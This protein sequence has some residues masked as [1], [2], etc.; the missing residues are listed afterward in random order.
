MAKKRLTI[1]LDESIYKKLTEQAKEAGLTKS[2]YLTTLI[3]NQSKQK[4]QQ[5]RKAQAGTWTFLRKFNYL[6][7]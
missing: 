4:G 7:C 5:K 1:S 3:A 2:A 6:I